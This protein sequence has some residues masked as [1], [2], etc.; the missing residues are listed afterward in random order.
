MDLL[1]RELSLDLTQVRKSGKE[2]QIVLEK[3][4]EED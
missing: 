1:A 4:R 3:T 2:A